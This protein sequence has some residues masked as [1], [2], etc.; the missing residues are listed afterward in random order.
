MA[1]KKEG[2]EGE[3]GEARGRKKKTANECGGGEGW[4]GGEQ[5]KKN[6]R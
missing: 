4:G 3:G 5:G 2:R 6:D 1:E